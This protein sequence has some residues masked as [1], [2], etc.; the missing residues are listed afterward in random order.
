MNRIDK[1]FE[2][3]KK[4]G[5]KALIP[6]L[7]AGDPDLETT[8]KLVLTLEQAG[9]DLLE[10]GVPF[11]DPIAEG[12]EVG[13]ASIRSLNNGTTL[14]KIFELIKRVRQV[15]EIPILL[16]LYINSIF[17]FGTERFFALC[18]ECGADGV[19]VL[20][21]P[22]EEREE[23]Q[24]EAD[25]AGVYSISLAADS[26]RERMKKIAENCTGFL[27]CESSAGLSETG[28]DRSD[29]FKDFCSHTTLCAPVCFGASSPEQAR[30]M[31]PY[32]D[33]V[34]IEDAVVRLIGE[35]GRNSQKPVS[36]FMSSFREAI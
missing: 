2:E 25:R 23:I 19:I 9:A 3:L 21:M 12:I 7:T 29:I 33:G 4:Q 14:V 20:D 16:T 13:Q 22:Y 6:F 31:K 18:R 15:T 30:K 5:K 11:S 34:I 28:E 17:R 27:Y 36:E 1:K 32:C 8:E 10:L 35:Y 26:S 24:E